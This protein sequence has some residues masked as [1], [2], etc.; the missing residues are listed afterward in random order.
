MFGSQGINTNRLLEKDR[1]REVST[2]SLPS[3]GSK[4]KESNPDSITSDTTVSIFPALLMVLN[5]A[6][7]F[8]F[9]LD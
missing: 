7:T 5:S 6:W 4:M 8:T 9:G 3:T 1:G 2:Q